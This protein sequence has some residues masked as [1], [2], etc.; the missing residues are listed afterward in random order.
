MGGGGA[1][2]KAGR[3]AVGE[4]AAHA[5]GGPGGGEKMGGCGAAFS[6]TGGPAADEDAVDAPGRTLLGFFEAAKMFGMSVARSSTHA[7]PVRARRAFSM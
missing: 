6:T 1:F 2:S 7:A 3:P 4:E 5:G